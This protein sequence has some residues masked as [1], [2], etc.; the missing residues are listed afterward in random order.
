M[1]PCCEC[2]GKKV[3]MELSV[4]CCAMPPVTKLPNLAANNADPSS[5]S[6]SNG[7]WGNAWHPATGVCGYPSCATLTWTQ[8][9]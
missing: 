8:V 2:A 1:L 5:C 4:G 3:G 9:S 6:A 7:C